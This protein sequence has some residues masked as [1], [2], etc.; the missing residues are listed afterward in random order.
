MSY[1]TAPP[2]LW[3]FKQ[4][5]LIIIM[6]NAI[7]HHSEAEVRTETTPKTTEATPARLVVASKRRRLGSSEF[8]ESEEVLGR[9]GTVLL[10]VVEGIHW[11]VP[12]SKRDLRG[13]REW[14]HIFIWIG[15]LIEDDAIW[16]HILLAA[17]GAVDVVRRIYQV[18]WRVVA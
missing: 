8:V 10:G 5:E 17:E 13:S 9:L 18:L 2:S 7:H 4:T 16:A 14:W 6:Y 11:V 12:C 15:G 1:T 3:Q